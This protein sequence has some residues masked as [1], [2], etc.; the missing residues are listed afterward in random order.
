VLCCNEVAELDRCLASARPVVDEIIVGA[1]DDAYADRVAEV[2]AR[3]G[4]RTLAVPWTDDFAAARNAVLD[5]A[6]GGWILSLDADE[7]LSPATAAA[8]PS[9]VAACEA[10]GVRLMIH[11]IC[12]PG[13]VIVNQALRLFRRGPGVRW[14]ERV[15]E[16]VEVRSEV[17]VAASILHHGY[18]DPAVVRAKQHR[19]LRLLDLALR[20]RPADMRLLFHR[21]HCLWGFGEMR[22][23]GE[24]ARAT[25]RCKDI[26]TG[27]AAA[28]LLI[29]AHACLH[30]A[31]FDG[32]ERAAH[33]A[34]D[35]MP[36]WIDPLWVL[37]DVARRQGRHADTIRHFTRFLAARERLDYDEGFATRFAEL[38][39]LGARK[40]ALAHLRL[41]QAYG[42]L[43]DARQENRAAAQAAALDAQLAV[44]IEEARRR[45]A[46]AAMQPDLVHDSLPEGRGLG[47]DPLAAIPFA[48]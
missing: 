29:L 11:N 3:H 39:A 4:A 24:A 32:A 43:G 48:P 7:E 40:K 12:G 20:E 36:N 13:H 45:A 23:A 8:L 31:D 28:T 38:Y 15:H 33:A 2:A 27:T 25:L 10:D 6:R 1:T 17:T 14:R 37:G 35:I 44:R 34:L 18:A 9:L 42:A 30:G 22:G 5:A 41:A 16:Y 26:D 46:S 47:C 19:N 21:A